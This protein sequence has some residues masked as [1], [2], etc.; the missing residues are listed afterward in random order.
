MKRIVTIWLLCAGCILAASAQ[1]TFTQ[2]LQEEKKGEGKVTIT[3]DKAIEELVNG[4]Q[5]AVT[6]QQQKTTKPQTSTQK[7]ENK[8]ATA[9]TEQQHK[10]D[11]GTTQRPVVAE[12]EQQSDTTAIDDGRK[13]IMKGGYKINGYR[14]QVYAGGNSRDARIK[15]ERIGKEINALF[16]GEPVYVHF[17]SPRWICR[18]GNYRSYEEANE[19]LRAVKKLGY[20]SAIIVKGKITVPYLTPSE[21]SNAI[22]E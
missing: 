18:M 5:T 8:K 22:T 16:P 1:T 2:R 20:S 14:V 12:K 15:A 17:Y 9:T 7:E 10:P 4:P 6:T 3:Q 21:P 13:K 11:S 19:R